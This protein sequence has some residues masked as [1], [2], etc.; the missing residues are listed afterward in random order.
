MLIKEVAF[1]EAIINPDYSADALAAAIALHEGFTYQPSA[2]FF[3][4]QALGNENSDLFTTTRHL[5]ADYLDAIKSGMEEGECLV[6]ALSLIHI[7][8]PTRL[9]LPSR[10]P[11]SA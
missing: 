9:L 7:S 6:I 10:M 3:W 2:D 8:E 5:T 4:K 11:S 1:G